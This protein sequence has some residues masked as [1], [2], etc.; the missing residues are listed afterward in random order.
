MKPI[1][2][3]KNTFQHE[4]TESALPVIIDFWAPWCGPCR[5][6]GPRLDEIARLY[7]GRL[8]VVKV[9]V[10]DEPELAA[11]F[12]VSGIPTMVAVHRGRAVGRTVGAV[13]L[14]QLESVAD[15]LTTLDA[16]APSAKA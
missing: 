13:G 15:R 16:G 6:L 12:Q 9:N 4:V 11:G 8:K 5:V 1:T 10:D 3:T 2:V 7:A 14:A